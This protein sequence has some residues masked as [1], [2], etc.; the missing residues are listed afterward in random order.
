MRPLS[1]CRRFKLGSGR[2]AIATFL[3]GWPLSG[4][5]RWRQ[6]RA[7]A[8]GQPALAFY[9][10]DPTERTYL[11]FALNVLTLRGA[12]ISDVTAFVARSTEAT[13]RGASR[14]G[15][16]SRQTRSGCWPHSSA[17][18]AEPSGLSAEPAG[19]P[20]WAAMS[21]HAYPV[22]D[23]LARTGYGAPHDKAWCART[24]PGGARPPARRP[25]AWRLDGVHQEEQRLDGAGRRL[26]SGPVDPRRQARQSLLLPQHRRRWHDRRAQRVSLHSFRPSGRRLVRPRQ[27]P[28][29]PRPACPPSRSSST[30]RQTAGWSRPRTRST[31]RSSTRAASRLVPP[32]L[33]GSST[34]S[35][36]E[37]RRR[38]V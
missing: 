17:S 27:W 36:S 19:Q 12:L 37:R 24:R 25:R 23:R 1:R 8:N 22:I 38:S 5:W 31:R 15:P 7:H 13:D 34:S 3:A 9:T 30:F 16:S 32:C 10:W 11:P 29:T 18:A 14:A 2:E 33:P 26:R 21:V 28:L 20:A 35:I 4:N 6:V